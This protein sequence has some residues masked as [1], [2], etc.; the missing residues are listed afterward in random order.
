M[1]VFSLTAPLLKQKEL[2]PSSPQ[3]LSQRWPSMIHDVMRDVTAIQVLLPLYVR[4]CPIDPSCSFAEGSDPLVGLY[5][6]RWLLSLYLPTTLMA[7]KRA[8]ATSHFAG[9]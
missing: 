4:S 8:S 9:L 6:P 2:S 1:C 7:A 3:L 5:H